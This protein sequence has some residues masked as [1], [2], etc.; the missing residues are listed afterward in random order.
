MRRADPNYTELFQ[1]AAEISETF[2]SHASEGTQ[3]SVLRLHN[4][5]FVHA[6]WG[7]NRHFTVRKVL[8]FYCFPF[9]T[10]VPH[11]FTTFR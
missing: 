4:N 7:C 1:T 8:S 10:I 2:Y 9:S 6:I 3:V 5:T 11:N